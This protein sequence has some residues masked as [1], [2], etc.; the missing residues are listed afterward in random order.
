M[1][2]DFSQD[3]KQK[4]W[5]FFRLANDKTIYE[6]SMHKQLNI[7]ETQMRRCDQRKKRKVTSEIYYIEKVENTI[8]SILL[9]KGKYN[10]NV[11][12]TFGNIILKYFSHSHY[13]AFC[14]IFC[15]SE[16]PSG[17]EPYGD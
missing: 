7:K 3:L 4:F 16:N 11:Y 13:W 5:P 15:N 8:E 14:L 6:R 10:P 2:E 1:N 17:N 12:T 9:G